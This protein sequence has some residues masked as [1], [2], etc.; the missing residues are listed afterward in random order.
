MSNVFH[1][2]SLDSMYK[3]GYLTIYTK[4]EVLTC[5]AG[6]VMDPAGLAQGGRSPAE[7][8]YNGRMRMLDVERQPVTPQPDPCP[9]QPTAYI[10]L[11]AFIHHIPHRYNDLNITS[12]IL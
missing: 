8:C 2:L 11:F 6:G 3:C 1:E 10:C 5:E 12:G 9:L 4:L 7:Q